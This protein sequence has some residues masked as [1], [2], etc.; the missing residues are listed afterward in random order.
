MV[1]TCVCA[2]VVKY[3]GCSSMYY[4]D[5]RSVRT[6]PVLHR[7]ERLQSTTEHCAERVC[8]AA[9]ESNRHGLR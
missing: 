2:E 7:I 8:V 6:R 3:G 4:C 5:W 1:N 9:A